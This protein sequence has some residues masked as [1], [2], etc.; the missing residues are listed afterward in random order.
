MTAPQS[1]AAKQMLSIHLKDK[2][3]L[4]AS[5]M[6]FLVHGGLFVPTVDSYTLGDEVFVLVTLPEE[7]DRIPVAGQVVWVTP[8]GAVGNRTPGIGVQFNGQDGGRLRNR[9]ENLLAG[10]LNRDKPTHTL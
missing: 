3:A 8:R 4:Y 5:Y 6:P 10:A 2:N 1:R 9:I 7:T